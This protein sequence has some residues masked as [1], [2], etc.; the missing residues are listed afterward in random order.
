[1]SELPL[2]GSPKPIETSFRPEAE[3]IVFSGDVVDFLAQLPDN[4]VALIMT[5]P[6]YNLFQ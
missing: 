2:F 6:P 1:M 5:S 3:I 4:S